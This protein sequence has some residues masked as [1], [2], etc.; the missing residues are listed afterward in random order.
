MGLSVNRA[1]SGNTDYKSSRNELTK[2]FAHRD[3]AQF[4]YLRPLLCTIPDSRNKLEAVLSD[5]LLAKSRADPRPSP[6]TIQSLGKRQGY[7]YGYTVT[8]LN[9]GHYCRI[10]AGMEAQSSTLWNLASASYRCKIASFFLS[11]L[12]FINLWSLSI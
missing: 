4:A 2:L 7:G 5:L 3:T 9:A 10:R 12:H 1:S 6:K 11:L 8:L